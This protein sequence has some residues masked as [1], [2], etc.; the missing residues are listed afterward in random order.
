MEVRDS[1]MSIHPVAEL[2]MSVVATHVCK[3]SK[4]HHTNIA[5][6]RA[7]T[8]VPLRDHNTTHLSRDLR[9]EPT[10]VL[11]STAWIF[12]GDTGRSRGAVRVG[13]LS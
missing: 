9:F 1:Q 5:E 10:A 13:W 6:R 3:R 8:R 7:A 11:M 12:P 2:T 4:V